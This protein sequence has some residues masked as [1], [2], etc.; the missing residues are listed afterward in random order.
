MMLEIGMGKAT[1][2]A[3]ASIGIPEGIVRATKVNDAGKTVPADGKPQLYGLGLASDLN[4][5][6]PAQISH[7]LSELTAAMGV[8]RT[9]YK[10]LVAAAQ[11]KG[12]V[13]AHGKPKG[14]VPAYLT[15]QIASYQAALKRLNGG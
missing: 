4:V 11:P 3:L 5:S 1:K 14:P 7:A 12:L 9:A 2:D 8:V 15:K 6:T 13:E 10:D